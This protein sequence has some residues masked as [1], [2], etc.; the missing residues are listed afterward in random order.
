M[1]SECSIL[2]TPSIFLDN[3]GRGYTDEQQKKY[4]LVFNF[5]E[6][7]IDQKK[8]IEKGIEIL[9]NNKSSDFWKEKSKKIIEEKIDP[10]Q[11]FIDF[12]KKY[13]NK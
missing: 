8:S 4:G 10:T 9:Q 11:F 1:A 2:G 7:L 6:S 12:I 5:T 13:E 3:S